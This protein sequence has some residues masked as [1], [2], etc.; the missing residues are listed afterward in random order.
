MTSPP[1]TGEKDVI[2][3]TYKVKKLFTLVGQ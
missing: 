2:A 1:S 3:Y